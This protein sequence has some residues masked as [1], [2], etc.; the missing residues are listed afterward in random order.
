MASGRVIKSLTPSVGYVTM[1][2]IM[3][4]VAYYA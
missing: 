4:V 2:H 1:L 3:I